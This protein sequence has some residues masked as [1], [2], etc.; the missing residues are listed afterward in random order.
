MK[1]I[2]VGCNETTVTGIK[3]S[4]R[5]VNIRMINDNMLDIG[6]CLKVWLVQRLA[7][8]KNIINEIEEEFS[9]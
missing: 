3:I 9:R 6:S 5:N 2:Q 8:F 4:F 7:V 1:L